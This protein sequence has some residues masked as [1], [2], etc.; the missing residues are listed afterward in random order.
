MPRLVGALHTLGFDKVFDTALSADMTVL[1]EAGEFLRRLTEGQNLPLLTSCCPAWVKFCETR[2]PDLKPNIS[3]C[4]SP[5]QM[6]GALIREYFSKAENNG[7]KRVVSV[8]IMP[9]TAKKAE[10][11]RPESKTYGVQDVDISLTTSELLEMIKAAGL[12]AL[13]CVP[14][15]TDAPFN[16]GSGGG[17]IF[18]VTGGVTEAVLRYLSPKLGLAGPDWIATSGVRGLE[19]TK[20][21][22]IEHNGAQLRIAIVNGLGNADNL[23]KKIRAGEDYF[24]L[25]E[26]MSCP[27]GCMMGGGQPTDSYEMCQ[28]RIQRSG[29][30]YAA[31]SACPVKTAQDNPLIPVVYQTIIQGLEHKMLHRNFTGA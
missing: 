19:E 25:I 14:C 17:V 15:D 20:Q 21:T 7:G 30:L 16:S 26:V 22:I 4:R 3:T 29:G 9:C 12:T 11:L 23:I 13:D 27:G 28:N 2:Y 5:Q 31:D 6:M 18:G 8:S 1:E 24:D 10:I